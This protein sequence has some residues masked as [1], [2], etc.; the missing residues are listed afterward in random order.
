VIENAT[1]E[2]LIIPPDDA[3]PTEQEND[4]DDPT[5]PEAEKPE[6]APEAP[7]APAEP[8]KAF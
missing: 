3:Y 5:A 6:A 8:G 4:G 2:S 7:E 1:G